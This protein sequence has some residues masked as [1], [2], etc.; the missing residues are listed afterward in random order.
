[1]KTPT[2][3]SGKYS[4]PGLLKVNLD[5]NNIPIVEVGSEK[6]VGSENNILKVVYDNRP[7][8]NFVWDSFE[9]V[10]K[11]VQNQWSKLPKKANVIGTELQKKIEKRLTE[12]KL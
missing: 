12:N 6:D 4:L 8:K 7:I 3:D 10:R 5:K 9:D 1:M 11:R 2:T